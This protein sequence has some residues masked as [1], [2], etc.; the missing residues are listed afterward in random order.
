VGRLLLILTG[1]AAF[2]ILVLLAAAFIP[3]AVLLL[4]EGLLRRHAPQWVKALIAGGTILFAVLAFWYS[5]TL[6][7][8]RLFGLLAFQIIGFCLSGWLILNRDHRTL[9]LRE[10]TMVTRLALSLL[11]F[12]PLAAGDFLA[13]YF[14]L[15]VQ[16]SPLGVLVLCWLAIGLARS[17]IGHGETLLILFVMIM[18]AILSGGLIALVVGVGIIDMLMI[19]ALILAVMVLVAI[20]QDARSLQSE[21]RSFGLLHHMATART[22]DPIAFLR[23]LRTHPLVDGAVV[24]NE[25][26]LRGLEPDTVSAIF[27]AAPVLRRTA[28]PALGPAADDHIAHLFAHYGATHIILACP[29]PR[30]LIALSMPSLGLS[31]HAEL[32]LEVVQRMAALI[33]S[34]QVKKKGKRN[35]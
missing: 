23:D 33:A 8:V 10:N 27:Q 32:E 20:F 19:I 13:D 16:F 17:Q 25:E 14:G 21:E 3:L 22:K 18:A 12:I 6:D 30:V 7:P 9:S 15:P 28:P 31:P 5:E 4:T 2:R 24:V 34:Q 35:G 26:S 11:L 1:I 29:A